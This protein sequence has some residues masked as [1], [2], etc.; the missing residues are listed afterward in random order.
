MSAIKLDRTKV[1]LGSVSKK[2]T[3]DAAVSLSESEAVSLVW[4]LTKKAYS[5]SDEDD[6][7]IKLQRDVVKLIE[8]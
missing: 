6:D 1:T 5:I 2:E 7:Q 4:E 3:A 8:R